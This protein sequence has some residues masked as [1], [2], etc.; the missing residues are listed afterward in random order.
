MRK[1]SGIGSSNYYIRVD[2][3]LKPRPAFELVGGFS[4]P[5]TPRNRIDPNLCWRPVR[6]EN[7]ISWLSGFLRKI[8]GSGLP[9]DERGNPG[10]CW[11]AFGSGP[12]VRGEEE[13]LRALLPPHLRVRGELEGGDC[14]IAQ[15]LGCALPSFPLYH[16]AKLSRCLEANQNEKKNS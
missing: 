9:G 14:R 2:R 12:F 13:K 4:T 1:R 11:A 8:T 6:E 15:C 3:Y 7:G 5:E 10:K 16:S